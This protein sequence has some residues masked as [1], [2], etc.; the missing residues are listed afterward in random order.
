[1]KERIDERFTAMMDA[2]ALEEVA[3]LAARGLREGRTARKAI[4][5]QQ[6][7]AQLDGTLAQSD[8]ITA[9]TLATRRYVRRQESWFRPDPRI[10]WLDAA[11]PDLE[12][13]ASAIVAAGGRA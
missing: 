1:M 3:A 6:A 4:G 5:Y 9:T 8:A 12:A 10:A 13:R 7:L 2:G 11:A